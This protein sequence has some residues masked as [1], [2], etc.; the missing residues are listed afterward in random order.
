L[1]ED[2]L[3]Y[4]P[5]VR[6]TSQAILNHPYLKGIVQLNTLYQDKS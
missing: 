5:K 2:M 3:K 6:I 1:I 4:D